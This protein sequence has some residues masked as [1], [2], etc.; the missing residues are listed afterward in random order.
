[1]AQAKR[2]TGTITEKNGKWI[3]TGYYKDTAG[4]IK[5]PQK[6]FNSEAEALL[7]QAQQI[8]KAVIKAEMKSRDITLQEVY[9][10]WSKET[11]VSET[12]KR[13]SMYNINTHIL[14]AL[15]HYKIKRLPLITVEQFL[16]RLI[17]EGKSTKTAYNIYTDLKMLINY[18]LDNHII[19][20]NPIAKIK[21][22]K[23]KKHK[24]AENVMSVDEYTKILMCPKNQESFYYNI[25]M[26]L[27]ETGLRVSELAIEES[28]IKEITVNDE[29]IAYIEL[30]KTI[31]RVSDD[32]YKTSQIKIINDMKTEGS[33]RRIYI[34]AY[35]WAAVKNQIAWKK[36]NK[37]K[38]K[39]IFTTSTGTLLEE[40]NVLRALYTFCKNANIKR[41]SL[42]SLRKC[43]INRAI[44][45]DIPIFDLAKFT[46]HSMQTMFNYYHELSHKAGLNIVNATEEDI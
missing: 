39:M 4:R 18:A 31:H 46:G 16:N 2:G 44:Q 32:D 34:N 17:D 7:F 40:R 45:H 26:F 3:W 38:S 42:H 28:Q 21:P 6:T 43:F 13:N 30:D 8:N 22:P 15:G 12:T 35:A 41:Y 14:P 27:G 10:L 23:P 11:T 24:T 36:R 25:I 20:E 33:E 1:M 5:R 37:I 9:V 19:Y 29:K